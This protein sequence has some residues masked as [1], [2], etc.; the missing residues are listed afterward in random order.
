[1]IAPVDSSTNESFYRC[2][3]SADCSAGSLIIG[4]RKV[5]VI[6]QETSID[7]FTIVVPARAAKRLK[8]GTPWILDYD[9]TKTETHAQWFYHSPDGE[10]QIGL[11]RLRDVTPEPQ[12]GAWYS[13]LLPTRS[14]ASMTD[15]SVAYAGFALVLF[16]VMA[17]PGVGDHLGTASHIEDAANWIYHG[18]SHELGQWL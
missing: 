3:I 18:V 4:R 16:I 2:K 9:G 11:R 13:P 10:T 12:I 8:V 14:R 5:N 15:S 7:G 17:M 1:M 6:I